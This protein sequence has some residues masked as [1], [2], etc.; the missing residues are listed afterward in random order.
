MILVAQWLNFEL[1]ELLTAALPPLFNHG[2]TVSKL[3]RCYLARMIRNAHIP[4]TSI[5]KEFSELSNNAWV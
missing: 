4:K 1:F 3:N 5:G 2:Y